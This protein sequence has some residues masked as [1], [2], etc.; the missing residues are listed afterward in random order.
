MAENISFENELVKLRSVINGI[1]HRF[2]EQ[3][4]DDLAQE[5]I[6]GLYSAVRSFDS[7]RGVPFEAYAVLCI[8]RKMYT[9]CT[10]FI[11]NDSNY[12]DEIDNLESNEVLEEDILHKALI[13][14][15][16]SRLKQNLSD[17]EK[18]VLELYLK[19]LSYFEIA[20]RLSIAEKSVDNAMSRIKTKLKKFLEEQN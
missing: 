14:D 7:A 17:M 16:F 20:S 12:I 9:Y 11:K 8:K 19:E 10:H 15:V 18:S 5:G 1:A 3:H 13:E 4:R 6:L 2:P